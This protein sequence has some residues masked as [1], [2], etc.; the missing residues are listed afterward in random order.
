MDIETEQLRQKLF[1][2]QM[3][4]L[5]CQHRDVSES[6]ARFHSSKLAQ[7][8]FDAAVDAHDMP[9]GAINPPD[10]YSGD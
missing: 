3:A 10:P 6:I 7:A 1:E 8:R 2:T 4:L 5:Q 9:S